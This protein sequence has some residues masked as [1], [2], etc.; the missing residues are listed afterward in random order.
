MLEIVYMK[1]LSELIAP[2]GILQILKKIDLMFLLW[3]ISMNFIVIS[4]NH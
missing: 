1:I 2:K 3:D 4:N